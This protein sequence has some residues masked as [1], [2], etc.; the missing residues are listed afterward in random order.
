MP[1]TTENIKT[2]SCS[3][4]LNKSDNSSFI[5]FQFVCYERIWPLPTINHL[6]VHSSGSA[7]GPRA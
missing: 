6:Y 5:K 1:K 7:I 4:R 2:G 3:G